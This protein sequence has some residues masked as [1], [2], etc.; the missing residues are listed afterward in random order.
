MSFESLNLDTRLLG[1]L[2]TLGFTAP[3]DIQREAIPAALE[4]KDLMA[5]AQTG[6]GKTAAFVLPA[7]HRLLNEPAGPGRGPR[8][9][10]LTPTRE[11]AQ[12]ITDAIHDFAQ[13]TKVK[14]GAIVGGVPYY[15][16]ERMLSKPLDILI[17]TPGRLMDH[18]ARGR[19]DFSRLSMLILDEA[20]R[21]LDMGF[22]EDVEAIAAETPDTRQT[23]LF[24]ATLE[25]EIAQVAKR[26][27]KDP[28]R[29]QISGV[30]ERHT[31]ITQVVHAADHLDHKMDLL[32]HYLADETLTQTVVFVSTKASTEELAAALKDDGHA[33]MP[34]H[35]DM[36]QG[37][38]SRIMERMQA[39][40]LRVL[41]ATDVAARGLDVKG[42]SHVVNF[43]L[44][45]V[46]EDYVHRIGRT[47]R[48]GATGTAVSLVGPQ[49][50]IKLSRIEKLTG[51]NFDEAVIEGLEPTRGRP[52]KRGFGGKGGFGQKRGFGGGRSF[53]DK[54]GYGDK[55][56]F[57]GGYKGGEKKPWNDGGE[58]RGFNKDF[59]PRHDGAPRDGAAR[60]FAPREHAPRDFNNAPRGDRP[61]FGERRPFGGAPREF[62]N[63]GAPRDFGNREGG[64]R[65]S[66]NRE[67]GNRDGAPRRDFAPRDGAPRGDRPAFGGERRP[68]AGRDGAPREFANKEFG[69]REGGNRD[70][71]PRREF[72]PRDGA[73][74]GERRDFGN[75]DQAPRSFGER[76]FA[77]R[78]GAPRGDRPAFGGERR[79][80]P[81]GEVRRFDGDAPAKK[82]SIRKD[83]E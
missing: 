34:L 49:D 78:D 63:G 59:A 61:A 74:R 81:Q 7:L 40:R 46:A 51:Q 26:L 69:N 58:Y 42:M 1:A 37:M 30:K 2:Q 32:R 52:Q 5:S 18:M 12:Q 3:T 10:I 4:G 53:G 45:M 62:G 44:P 9:L 11:L 43:D 31:S 68:Y 82:R 21:M 73:P 56:G 79:P 36:K 60:D 80:A 54:G 41:V 64:N 16:Q 77:P 22:V 48:G 57:G 75:K 27:L 67:F 14:S 24:S 39:G 65:D 38:R 28:Q 55:R 13:D 29:I 15:S 33:A 25:G 83:V 47:G 20:D 76:N 17:A 50:W 6:T 8:V 19:I 72:A 35:G 66:G 70:G 71:A 23:L